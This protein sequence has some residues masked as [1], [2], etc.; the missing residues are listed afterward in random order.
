[1]SY[2]QAVSGLTTDLLSGFNNT[3]LE[4]QNASNAGVLTNLQPAEW[5]ELNDTVSSMAKLNRNLTKQAT[6][7]LL[8]LGIGALPCWAGVVCC[9]ALI[10]AILGV[11]MLLSTAT[12][13]ICCDVVFQH[14]MGGMFLR[15]TRESRG[16][17]P[18]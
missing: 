18:A 5:Q 6:G 3:L 7:K 10:S 16:I 1:M 11:H 13:T 14:L 4:Y 9:R 15:R 12:T 2:E 17:L 8:V